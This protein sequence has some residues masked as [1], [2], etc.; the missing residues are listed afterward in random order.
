MSDYIQPTDRDCPNCAWGYLH[1]EDSICL[2]KD[3]EAKNA[4]VGEGA[5]TDEDWDTGAKLENL[6]IWC[7]CWNHHSHPGRKA[8]LDKWLASDE[9]KHCDEAFMMHTVGPVDKLH[10]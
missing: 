10:L 3:T 4:H 5:Y 7:Q 2:I 1:G 9:R 6:A 8:A